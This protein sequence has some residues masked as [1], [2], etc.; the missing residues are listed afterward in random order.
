MY[1]LLGKKLGHSFSKT[2]H[3]EFTSEEY[4]L[5]ETNNLDQ[6]FNETSFNGLNVTI[7]YKKEI[8]PYLD[9]LSPEANAIGVV[10][11]VINRNNKLFGYNTDYY[12]LDK[13]LG[14]YDIKV[15]NQTVLILGNGS[16]SSTISYYCKVKGAK[17]IVVLGRN[18]NHNEYY[19]NDISKFKDAT[20]VFNATPVGMFPN[21]SDNTL[22]DL[23]TLPKVETVVDMVY[24]P[25]RS[26]L[27][28]AAEALN[29][30]AVNGLLMLIYQAIKAIELFHNTVISDEVVLKYY[31]KLLTEK[32]NLI[33]V[34]M[35]MSGKSFY[36][37]LVSTYYNKILI[38]IDDEISVQA[39]D[40]IENIFRS[41]GEPHFR[42]IEK[43]IISKYSKLNNQAISC[44]G[45][46]ILNKENMVNLKQNGIII[47]IDMPLDLLM[48]CNPKN[49]PLLQDKDNLVKLY[50]DRIS[51]YKTFQ[52]ITIHKT[53]FDKNAVMQ[54]IEVKI[55]EYIST[56]WS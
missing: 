21:N 13:S 6:F 55:N 29:I 56:K 44:G 4:K 43:Q 18:P 26:N 46:V 45:G 24:N 5:I 33:F 54:Q 48:R 31:H 52:D 38:E 37:R 34:G 32:L 14:Y 7:P 11:T 23:S 20:I 30:K 19:F 40:S 35:P 25:L 12:G 51:L 53:S 16:T 1:G 50:N 47:F 3:E 10:N 41:K 15:K 9:K 28:I 2:I 49:R 17:K 39:K 8:I 27:I 36:S 22:I 42:N